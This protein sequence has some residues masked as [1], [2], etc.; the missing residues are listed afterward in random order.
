MAEGMNGF[1]DTN[2][3]D[4][5]KTG[6]EGKP[7]DSKPIVHGADLP[8]APAL[9]PAKASSFLPQMPDI[10]AGIMQWGLND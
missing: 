6:G 7:E 2:Q 8:I 3:L 10:G 1:G 4:E 9:A 5:S